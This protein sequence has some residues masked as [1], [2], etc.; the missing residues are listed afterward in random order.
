[1]A[2]ALSV[3]RAKGI[4]TVVLS[5]SPVSQCAQVADVALSWPVD[6]EQG[7]PSL[8]PVVMLIDALVRA[9]GAP[10]NAG[11]IAGGLL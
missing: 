1:V 10:S 7:L 11:Q 4:P 8:T 5:A 3:A 2:N 6:A 9:L